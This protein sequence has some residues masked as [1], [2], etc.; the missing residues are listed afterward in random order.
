VGEVRFVPPGG[1][2]MRGAVEAERGRGCMVEGVVDMFAR[3]LLGCRLVA[4][5]SS[6]LWW[7]SFPGSILLGARSLC[8]G[9]SS[10]IYAAAAP[11]L[12]PDHEFRCRDPGGILLSARGLTSG[13]LVGDV[14]YLLLIAT[15]PTGV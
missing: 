15:V 6:C 5:E 7:P 3:Q 11:V 10:K 4:P 8:R 9:T 13:V 14:V 1:V 12:G 2:G